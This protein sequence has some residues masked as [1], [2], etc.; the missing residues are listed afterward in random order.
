MSSHRPQR[1]PLVVFWTWI[2]VLAGGLAIMI[3]VPW[4]EV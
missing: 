2:T 3:I 1:G 4:L